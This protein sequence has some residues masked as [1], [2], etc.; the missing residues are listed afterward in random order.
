MQMKPVSS[1]HQEELTH[2][3][4]THLEGSEPIPSTHKEDPGP[5]LNQR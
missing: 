5:G 2:D 4:A 1:T 3:S